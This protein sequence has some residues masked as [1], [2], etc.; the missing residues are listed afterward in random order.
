MS[1]D[2]IKKA[3]SDEIKNKT[4]RDEGH[5][6]LGTT[7]LSKHLLYRLLLQFTLKYHWDGWIYLIL[8]SSIT[9]FWLRKEA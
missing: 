3:R 4:T 1:L 6:A 8:I 7:Y 5:K 2:G 9:I